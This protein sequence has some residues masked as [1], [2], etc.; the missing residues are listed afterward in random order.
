MSFADLVTALAHDA[1]YGVVVTD[2][3]IDED[4]PCI[5]YAN[6]AFERMSGYSLA[7]MMGRSPRMFQ[8]PQTSAAARADIRKALREGKPHETTLLNY[9]KSGEPYRCVIKMFPIM[10]ADGRLVG[11]VAIER[12]AP[13]TRGRPKQRD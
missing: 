12:E 13:R 2:G 6:P 10:D 3:R 1:D 5:T 11:A 9:R 4:G 8:G 7:E